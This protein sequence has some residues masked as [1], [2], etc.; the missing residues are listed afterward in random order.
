MEYLKSS[1]TNVKLT[2]QKPSLA[3]LLSSFLNLTYSVPTRS[4]RTGLSM[5]YFLESPKSITLTQASG[6]LLSNMMFSLL[7]S[8][9][10]EEKACKPV[11]QM[12]LVFLDP[13]YNL[14]S[15]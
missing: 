14:M 15:R 3:P 6:C 4:V 2:M 8:Q 9:E 7:W 1:V 11:G 10:E 5:E 13:T 12:S